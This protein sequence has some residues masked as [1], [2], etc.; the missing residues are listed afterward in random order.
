MTGACH[1]Q[2]AVIRLSDLEEIGKLPI[3]RWSLRGRLVSEK[4]EVVALQ[5]MAVEG[6][7]V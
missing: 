3:C 1:L 2:G 5:P 4:F 7:A 6:Q